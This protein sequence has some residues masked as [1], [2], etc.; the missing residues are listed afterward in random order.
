MNIQPD[1]IAWMDRFSMAVCAR[2]FSAGRKLFSPNVRSFGTL[3]DDVHDLDSLVDRQWSITWQKTQHFKF[4][5]D[6]T[7]CHVSDNGRTAIIFSKWSSQ[8]SS[9]GALRQGRSTIVLVREDIADAW[10]AIHS[11][12]SLTP[13]DGGQ[14]D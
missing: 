4:E 2:D 12:F 9:D 1:V 13:L 7:T 8:R 5:T 6:S 14:L 3:A 10:V 11:H